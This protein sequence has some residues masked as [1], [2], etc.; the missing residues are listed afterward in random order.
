MHP[1]GQSTSAVNTTGTLL[2][3]GIGSRLNVCSAPPGL[4]SRTA[5]IGPSPARWGASPT[6]SSSSIA[7][8]PMVTDK[9][10]PVITGGR[11][12]ATWM[13]RRSK[14]AGSTARSATRANSSGMTAIVV[15]ESEEPCRI[16]ATG[17]ALV[18]A[19]ST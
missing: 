16:H 15:I 11:V 8:E 19:G 10:V 7:L 3:K 13:G 12:P 6:S 1:W 17:V 14:A 18:A 2:V 9:R 4:P 5:K